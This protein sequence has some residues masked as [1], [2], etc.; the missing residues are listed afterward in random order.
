MVGAGFSRSAAVHVGGSKRMPL[1]N[2]FTKR[3]VEKLYPGRDVSFVDPLRVAEEFRAY[4]GQS[5]LNDQIRFEIEDDAWKNGPLYQSLLSLP[6]TDVLTTN[7]DTLLERAAAELNSPYYTT[8]TKCTDLAWAPS[9]RIV[10]LHGTIGV[11]DKF[12]AAQ[13]DYRRY[14]ITFAPFVNLTRQVFIENE[15]C[16]LGFSG[17]DPN[18]LAWAGWVRDHLADHARKI[19]LVGALDLPAARRTQLESMNV[20]PIDLGPLVTDV[21]DVDL[22]HEIA[23]RLFLTALHDELKSHINPRDWRPTPT[24][25]EATTS[26]EE[27]R[28]QHT[29]DRGAARL[30][31]QLAQLK[32]TRESYPGWLVCP[33]S[34][35]WK[36]ANQVTNPWPTKAM[37]DA[38]KP[39]DRS[40]ILYELCWRKTIAFEPM[41]LWFAEMLESIADP[42]IPTS[43]SVR[44][45][46]EIALALLNHC[47]WLSAHTEDERQA[48]DQITQKLIMTISSFGE[49]LPDSAAEVAYHQA[50]VCRDKLDY[51]GL[52]ELVEKVT[53]EDP[54]WKLRKAALLS[55]LGRADEMSELVARA[56]GELLRSHRSDRRSIPILSRLVWAHWL[57][58]FVQALKFAESKE[59]LPSFVEQNY[60]HWKCDPWDYIDHIRE[61]LQERF[62]KHID[63]QV[64]IEP[65]FAQGHYRQ[66]Q[67]SGYIE[68]KSEELLL[69]DGLTR[70]V[71]IPLRLGSTPDVNL[72]SDDI[73]RVVLTGGTGD[74]LID[75]AWAI[76]AASTESSDSVKDYFTRVGVAKAK[77]D[78]V[79]FLAQRVRAAIE[80][81]QT[82]QQ[83]GTADQRHKSISMLRVLYEVLSRLVVRMPPEAATE[84]FIFTAASAQKPGLQHP[85]TSESFTHLAVNSLN[86]IPPDQRARLLP[87][88][89]EFPLT[90]E[91]AGER[92]HDWANPLMMINQ[93]DERSTYPSLDA[94][95]AELIRRSGTSVGRLRLDPLL[96]LL[97]ICA[98]PGFLTQAESANLAIAL[99]G[100]TP[101]FSSVPDTGLLPHTFLDLP[102]QD[103]SR[104]EEL[105]RRDLFDMDPEVLGNTQREFRSFPSP[106]M[107]RAIDWCDGINGAALS[108]RHRLLPTP[109]QALKIFHAMTAWRPSAKQDRFFGGHQD[110]ELTMAIGRALSNSVVPA[111]RKPQR[112][113]AR[114]DALRKLY[115][116]VDGAASVLPGFP[117]FVHLGMEVVTATSDILRNA[118][119]GRDHVSSTYAAIAI[120]RWAESTKPGSVPALDRLI[121]SVLAIIES[122][123]P[124]ALH[125]LIL[126]AN[127]LAISNRLS[128]YQLLA[129]KDRLPSVFESVAYEKIPPR[130]EV[131][132]NAS[133]IRSA[134]VVLARTLLMHFRDETGLLEIINLASKDS[135][136]EV[137]FA[138]LEKI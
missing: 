14:P 120:E 87:E 131:M 32:A 92:H 109:A 67:S 95:I 132:V 24:S 5:V 50:L 85:W 96:R 136:P 82:A 12:I 54:V 104:V 130:A 38:L 35:R 114:F 20:A 56:Y 64:A 15:L 49:Y 118:I 113:R 34:I 25:E 69:I 46:L 88:A 106:E 13:E 21:P 105:V 27:I 9:P 128:D 83:Q 93:L 28:L 63:Q 115:S 60:R 62:E 30:V 42:A 43:I 116:E 76:R 90:C 112:S 110:R 33:P 66:V 122:E 48:K 137:R 107:Q 22:K 26:I 68:G 98:K 129:L 94:R 58:R 70:V 29:P 103:P 31:A 57:L 17:D 127:K 123:M 108:K 8:V 91:L 2:Q 74:E 119:H 1:W 7:W 99:W 51:A 6:W 81:W 133:T 47:R 37:L 101:D 80:Y 53:G 61:K 75:G 100:A 126:L 89:L 97:R 39:E 41:E 111:L 71:G 77:L 86:S 78:V 11:T 36:L 4:F 84:I 19:Y 121:S 23:T 65:L 16:L 59:E 18:F 73:K 117:A 135:L 10:K 134:C 124:T 125:Q 40:R 55:E 3:L 45:Q 138:E 52:S 44:Q 79:V 102:S 72:L